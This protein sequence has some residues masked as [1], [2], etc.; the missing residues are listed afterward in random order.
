MA[1]KKKRYSKARKKRF[2]RIIILAGILFL[3]VILLMVLR[4][5]FFSDKS[6]AVIV[7]PSATAIVYQE[8]V[9]DTDIKNELSDIANAANASQA[10]YDEAIKEISDSIAKNKGIRVKVVNHSRNTGYSEKLRAVLELNGFTVS[11]G[12]DK[13][14]KRVSSVIIEKKYDISGEAITKLV[15]INRIRKELDPESRFDIVVVIGDDY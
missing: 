10:S 13:S 8:V 12:N 2:R 11:S 9:E 3:T 6:K 14:L 4:N 15:N 7:E 5:T 1:A